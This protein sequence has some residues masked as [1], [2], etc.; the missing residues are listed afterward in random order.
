MKT[1]KFKFLLILLLISGMAG[2]SHAAEI[3]KSLHKEFKVSGNS[4]FTLQ[5]KYGKVDIQNWEKNE[6]VIDVKIIIEHPSKEKAEK[7]LDYLNV[8]FSSSGNEIKAI[9]RIDDKFSKIRGSDW[10]DEKKFSINYT[11]K[12][13]K[14]LDINLYNKYGD[15]FIDELTGK[16]KV[17]IKYGNLQAN[18][19]LRGDTK[20]LSVLVV[21]YGKA[22]IDE[23]NWMK[24]EIKYSKLEIKKSRAIVLLSKYSKIYIDEAS[25]IVAE[26]KYDVYNIGKTE[27]FVVEGAY[28]TYK[29]DY[30]GKKLHIQSKYT[31]T[32]VDKIPAT[33]EEIDIKNSYG[34]V[35]LGIDSNAS[36][37]LKGEAKYADI[38]FPSGG[39]MNKIR[40]NTSSSYEGVVGSD[41]DPKAKVS[42]VTSY[43]GVKL[44]Y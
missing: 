4:V 17:E 24:I 6:L 41:P 27:N 7:L 20:P 14:S 35:K 21:G 33:F 32:S 43:G 3:S 38:S 16:A 2:F 36:Y 42:I 9:T 25:S 22:S 8:E 19:I 1:Q 29:L 28:S 23:V 40:G 18:K 10:G 31:H 26:S 30:L 5:N 15:T 13:P 44:N 37:H 11:V 34:G 12:M 39:K